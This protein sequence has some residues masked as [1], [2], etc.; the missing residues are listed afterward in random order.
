MNRFPF[1]SAVWIALASALLP[2]LA[3]RSLRGAFVVY[4][5][6]G[7]QPSIDSA[8][9][10]LPIHVVSFD[11]VGGAQAALLLLFC[12]IAVGWIGWWAFARDRD[13]SPGILLALQVLAGV[14]L[15]MSPVSFSPDPTAYVLYARLWG[16]FGVNPYRFPVSLPHDQLLTSLAPLWG[17]PVPANVYGPL[18]TLLAGSLARLDAPASLTVLWEMQRLMAVAAS[19]IAAWGLL[20]IVRRCGFSAGEAS[21]RVAAFAFHPFVLLETAV[22]GHNDMLMVACAVWAFALLE[23]APFAAGAL[24]G[25]SVAVKFVTVIIVPFF[26]VALW[27]AH[28]NRLRPALIAV[29]AAAL[30][31]AAAFGPFWIGLKTLQPILSNQTDVAVSPAALLSD[32]YRALTSSSDVDP[33]FPRQRHWR[34]LRHA[35]AGQ[36]IDLAL[37]GAWA[38]MTV[39][40]FYNFIRTSRRERGYLTVTG[41]LWALPA[42][43]SYYLVWLSPILVESSRWARYVWWLLMAGMLYYAQIFL[44]TFT[45]RQANEIYM[46]ALIFI[47][48]LASRLRISLSEEGGVQPLGLSASRGKRQ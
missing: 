44:G 48:L 15:A 14:L 12:V 47:P 9:L 30:V 5:G 35:S 46:L 19:V 37:V 20:R 7:T 45:W 27:R 3:E 6:R 32:A 4:R 41:F 25:A 21:A 1:W 17:A 13:R 33:V 8:V 23:E 16:V 38:L 2:R 36:L 26:L 29:V 10:A 28:G 42:L 43:G 31:L 39:F 40:L 22:N 18:W 11:V 34:I 24:L